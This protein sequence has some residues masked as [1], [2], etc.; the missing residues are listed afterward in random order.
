ME[1]PRIESFGRDVTGYLENGTTMYRVHV[2]SSR[3][4]ISLT[5]YRIE[6]PH[7]AIAISRALAECLNARYERQ[8]EPPD[9]VPPEQLPLFN[10]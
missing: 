3:H 5:V 9:V 2:W 10:L 8:G 6:S 4:D 1:Y 7:D